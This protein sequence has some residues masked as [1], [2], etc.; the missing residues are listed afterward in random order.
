MG[1]VGSAERGVGVGGCGNGSRLEASSRCTSVVLSAFL[2]PRGLT[3]TH[4]N[5]Q[6][7]LRWK[8]NMQFLFSCSGFPPVPG[9][10][11]RGGLHHGMHGAHLP[12]ESLAC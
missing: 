9:E 11:E 3:I 8:C 1:G 2:H 12:P 5:K 6:N 10:G 4:K 7:P